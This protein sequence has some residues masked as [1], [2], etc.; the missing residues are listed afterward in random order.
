M[1]HVVLISLVPRGNPA[2]HL[3]LRGLLLY[4]DIRHFNKERRER[5]RV[6]LSTVWC[7]VVVSDGLYPHPYEPHAHKRPVDM[8]K[9]TAM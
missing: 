9:I 6:T 8:L 7:V 1:S 5:F 3:V 2:R 4:S